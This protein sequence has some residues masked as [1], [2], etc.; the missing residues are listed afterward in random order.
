MVFPALYDLIGGKF[1]KVIII[2]KKKNLMSKSNKKLDFI[3]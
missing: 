1:Q 2:M 3:L